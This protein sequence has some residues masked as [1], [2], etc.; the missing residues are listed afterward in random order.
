MLMISLTVCTSLL[1]AISSAVPYL[2]NDVYS[3]VIHNRQDVPVQCSITWKGIDGVFPEVDSFLI[4]SQQD[5]TVNEKTYPIGSA[6]FRAI[7]QEIQCGDS[8][9]EHPFEGARGINL[10]WN[11]DIEPT[12]LIS[13]GPTK[14]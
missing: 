10:L 3:A 2:G 14:Q 5:V 6:F 12:G 11:F 7:I 4:P 1:F 9:L 13:A 8:I